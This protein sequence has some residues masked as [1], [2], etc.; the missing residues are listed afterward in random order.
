MN[1]SR[2]SEW[3]RWD[4]HLHTAS[5]YDSRYKADDADELL[6]ET[7]HK[8]NISAVAITDHFMIDA[9]RIKH[10]RSIAPDIVFFP[11][12]ELRTDKG[13]S[14]LHVII[15]FSDLLDLQ[16]LSEDFNAIMLRQ[17]AKQSNS[18]DTIYW[19]FED[20]VDFSNERDGLITIHAGKKTNGIDKEITNA[21]PVKEAIKVDIAEHVD[22]FEVG[23]VKD[24]KSYHDFVFK[25]IEEKPLIMCSDCHDPRNYTVK[26]NLWIKADLT[27]EGLKQCVFQPT[28]RVFIGIIPPALDRERKA[29]RVCIEKI[30]VNRIEKPRN[31]DKNWFSFEMPLNSG[32]V[33][34][35]GNKGSGKSAFSDILGQLCKCNNMS[36][37]S[38]LNDNRFRKMPKNYADDYT[39][40][41][42]WGDGHEETVSLANI[43]FNTT[44]EDAQYLPQSFIE[45]V[46][47]DIEN[48]FQKEIDKVIFSYVDRTERGDASTLQELVNNKASVV[49]LQ[50]EQI[51]KQITQCNEQIIKLEQ[52]KTSEYKTY[53]TDSLQKARENLER[54]EKVKPKEVD[55]P[56]A[57][58]EDKDYQEKLK[59]INGKIIELER[60]IEQNKDKQMIL[61]SL[62]DDIQGV[63]SQISQLELDGVELESNIDEFLSKYEIKL[64]E[65]DVAIKSPK[66]ALEKL[67]EQKQN[68]SDAIRTLL[69]DDE[70]GLYGKVEQLR[71]EKNTLISSANNEEK[72][73]QKYLQDLE[74]WRQTREEII[75]GEKID[76]TL[77]FFSAELDYINNRLEGDYI[78]LRA[79]RE[80]FI[81]QIFVLKQKLVEVYNEIYEPVEEEI[82]KILGDIEDTVEFSAEIQRVDLDFPEKVLSFINH[83]YAGIFKGK[84]EAHIKMDQMTRRTEFDK[85]ESIVQLVNDVLCVVD[86]DFDASEKKIADKKE[87]YNYL[88]DLDYVG[89]SFKLKMGGSDLEE[90]SPGERGI[91][92]LIFYL[93]LSK[94]KSPIIIDQPED[95]LDNQ[96]VYSKLVPCI[97]AAKKK[98]QVI[99]V[100][101][102]PNIAVACDAEQII[103]C[104]MDKN[105][106]KVDYE[107]GAI[108]K[109]EIRKHV[110]DVL[111]GTMPAFDLRKK[112]YL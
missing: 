18:E 77:S 83:S 58:E 51:K 43:A 63:L 82:R 56:Q 66:S 62:V 101:H 47:N 90:L 37:A 108:E 68:E 97:S 105:N 50:I 32:L 53:I 20:I 33:A 30:C 57:K 70:N 81:K 36:H 54:H 94:E 23:N 5:S 79:K 24:I 71:T 67:L 21:L 46:C 25:E 91:V 39:A 10:L 64:E 100:T 15:I 110:I 106:C 9:D 52:K 55:K 16:T 87:F 11:G 7:L 112:K 65:K 88:F 103:Y 8:N 29:E 60:Q 3:K 22:F 61:N 12:V 99:I 107:A 111:E 1:T 19:T 72:E 27:F 86:E 93:A 44:I 49:N 95:N 59:D 6:C 92:L 17:K 45:E 96:S 13:A 26:E 38:F 80:D 35:I 2:G 31:V 42:V 104:H 14:N 69:S 28:E 40:T 76:G 98:R 109:E 85:Q 41:I 102:N 73:Y 89:V 74:E 48:I 4:L 34:V 78:E 84:T 75:G